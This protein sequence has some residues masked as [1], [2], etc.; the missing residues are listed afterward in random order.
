MVKK[1]FL[2]AVMSELG[3][4]GSTGVDWADRGLQGETMCLKFGVWG[5]AT[6]LT[7]LSPKCVCVHMCVVCMSMHTGK[8]MVVCVCVQG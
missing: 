5:I 6:R 1:G 7:S 8:C 4:E 2:K 3:F